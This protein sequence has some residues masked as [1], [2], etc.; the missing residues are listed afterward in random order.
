MFK[1]NAM[2]FF[3]IIIFILSNEKKLKAANRDT[4]YKAYYDC[5]EDG[6]SKD[7]ANKIQTAEDC[8]KQSPMT[9]WKCCYFEYNK[10][11]ENNFDKGCMKVR[12]NN[13]TDLNDLKDFVSKLSSNVVFNCKQIYLS[14]SFIII[15]SM[16]L[17]L[18]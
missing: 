8:F 16:I 10:K 5:I 9:K 4:D 11:D 7:D 14:Y 12:K 2:I 13:I 3:F 18:I 6:K 1:S 15:I 17:L